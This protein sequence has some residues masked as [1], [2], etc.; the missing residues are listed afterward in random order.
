MKKRVQIRIY[1]DGRIQAE[2][3]GIKGKACTDYIRVLEELLDAEAYTSSYTPEYY[4]EQT[5][6][7]DL[8]QDQSIQGRNT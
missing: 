7:L 8:Q 5:V 4:E 6:H 2:T 1:P 3:Q